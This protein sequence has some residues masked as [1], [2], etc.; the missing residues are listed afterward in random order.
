MGASAASTATVLSS[1]ANPCSTASD[2][3]GLASSCSPMQYVYRPGCASVDMLTT[4]GR[5]PPR[6]TQTSRTARPIVA[7]ARQPEPKTPA[8]QLISSARRTGPLTI[9][10]GVGALVVALTPCRSNASSQTAS[11]AAI[12]TGRYSGR[13]PAITALIAIFSTVA[14]P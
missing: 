7:L 2:A 8:A 9:T 5:A 1:G 13:Q 6:F 10:S 11:T 4:P 14:R 3:H 12:T